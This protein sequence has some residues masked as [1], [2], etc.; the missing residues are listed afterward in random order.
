[1]KDA[2]IKQL[3]ETLQELQAKG[4]ATVQIKGTLMC[5]EDGNRIILTTEKQM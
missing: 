2:S 3:I 4:K 1:M 5:A